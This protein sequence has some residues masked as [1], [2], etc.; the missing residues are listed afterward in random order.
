[1]RAYA[2]TEVG[3]EHAARRSARFNDVLHQPIDIRVYNTSTDFCGHHRL[4]PIG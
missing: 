3:S 1:M 4:T 2:I